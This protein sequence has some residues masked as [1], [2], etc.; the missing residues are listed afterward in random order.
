MFSPFCQDFGTAAACIWVDGSSTLSSSVEGHA[1]SSNVGQRVQ[2]M[3]SPLHVTFDNSGRCPASDYTVHKIQ[4]L[5]AFSVCNPL[6]KSSVTF[7]TV[8]RSQV[9]KSGASQNDL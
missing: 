2:V 5:V 1:I 4:Y 6:F 7:E 9:C 8:S 3:N